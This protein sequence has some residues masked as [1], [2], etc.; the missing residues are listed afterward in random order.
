MPDGQRERERTAID[1][2]YRTQKRP[3]WT[4]PGD[5]DFLHMIS[6]MVKAGDEKRLKWLYGKLAENREFH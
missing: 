2:L 5:I 6:E 1:L 4:G 3:L